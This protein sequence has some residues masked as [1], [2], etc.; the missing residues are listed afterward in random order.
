MTVRLDYFKHSDPLPLQA[1]TAISG[2]L[3]ESDLDPQLL[4]LMELRASQL[5]G[6]A[7]CIDMHSKDLLALETPLPRIHL[8][9]AWREANVY[10]P[11][12]RAALGWTEA[13]TRLPDGET[14]QR[15]YGELAEHFSPRTITRLTFA[16]VVIN[17]WNRLSIAFGREPGRYRP[18]DLDAPMRQA[19]ERFADLRNTGERSTE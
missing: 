19:L 18:G 4:S 8:L 11:A 14:L 15:C 3:H 5:N 1:L 10:S 6:C 17:S 16:V 2:Y 7:Y 12:E 9:S 13:V